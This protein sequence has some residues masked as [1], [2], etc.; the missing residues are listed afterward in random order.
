[1]CKTFIFD[2]VT[3]V[4][5][6]RP[7]V[8][9]ASGRSARTAFTFVKVDALRAFF[10]RLRRWSQLGCDELPP[11]RSANHAHEHQV[12]RLRPT[13]S[14]CVPLRPAASHRVPLRPVP[15]RC[16][17]LRPVRPPASGASGASACV[18]LRPA[19]SRYV[20]LRPAASNV[21][22][23]KELPGEESMASLSAWDSACECPTGRARRRQT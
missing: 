1:M 13:A 5:A 2:I 10:T 23:T 11:V 6:Q 8:N 4:R 21:R 12:R 18:P 19:A 16:V 9:E 17:P 22:P 15:S 7:L 14:H 20:P 3:A